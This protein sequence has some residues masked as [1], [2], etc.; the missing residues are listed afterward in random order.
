MEMLK[1]A[2]YNGCYFDRTGDEDHRLCT[3]EG[4]FTCQVWQEVLQDWP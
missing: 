4:W 2:K 3:Q 1:E